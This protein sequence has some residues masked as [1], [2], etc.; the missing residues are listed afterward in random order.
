[1]L[2]IM[3]VLVVS[4]V[5]AGCSR[6]LLGTSRSSAPAPEQQVAVNNELALPPDLS[7]R[8]PGTYQAPPAADVSSD[9][10]ETTA[11]AAPARATLPPG[12]R[13]PRD[14]MQTSLD[15]YNISRLRPDGTVKPRGELMD[16][17]RLAVIAE[18]R[19]ANPNYGTVFNAGGLFNDN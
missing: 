5:L 18:K 11:P 10:I 13:N 3:A 9:A 6:G 16:E 2:R 1:M 19:K 7:L 12:S 8:A 4:L 17:I 14:P 15:K